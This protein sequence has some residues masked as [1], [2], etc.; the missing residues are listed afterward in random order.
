MRIAIIS[1]NK[2][3]EI[4]AKKLKANFKEA[5]LFNCR[6]DRKGSLR[7]LVKDIFNQYDGLIFISSLG[8]TVRLI[9]AL[10][11]SK[12]SDPAVVSV[13]TAGRFAISALSGHEGGANKLAFQVAAS[14]DTQPIVTTGQEVNK[15]FILGLGTRRG[16]AADKV[17]S[18][19]KNSL[20][21]KGLALKDIRIAATVDLK[22]DERGLV[23]ACS[24]L[25]LPLVFISKKDISNFKGE[26]SKSKVVKRNIGLDG[27]CEPCALLAGRRARLILKKEKQEGVTVAIAEEN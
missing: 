1:I 2:R 4:L 9:A 15:R 14:L 7:N 18:A 16:I 8:I 13:D 21:K 19:I 11:K 24:D 27:V 26:V 20:K 10:V 3:G 6:M 12:L 23:K 5:A 22:K 25:G 17:K